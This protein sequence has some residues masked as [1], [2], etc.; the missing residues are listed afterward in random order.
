MSKCDPLLHAGRLVPASFICRLWLDESDKYSPNLALTLLPHTF[1]RPTT[2]ACCTDHLAHA[3]QTL[4]VSGT[5]LDG[6]NKIT[7]HK[8]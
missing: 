5:Y 3:V 6:R 7:V 2:F 4:M 8:A 1:D